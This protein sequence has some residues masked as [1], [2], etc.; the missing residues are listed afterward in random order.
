MKKIWVLTIFPELFSNFLKVG[1]LGQS[2]KSSNP[3]F[4]IEII[5]IRDYSLDKHNKVDDMPFGGG[6]GMVMRADV[7]ENAFLKGVVFKEGYVDEYKKNLH[8]VLAGPRG[9]VLTSDFAKSF[10]KKYFDNNIFSTP[11]ESLKNLV[12]IC[13]RY[14]GIDQRFI[15]LYVDQ[16]ISVGD[17]I[18][19]GGE[20]PVMIM[21]DVFSRFLKGVLGNGESLVD[22]SFEENLLDHNHYTRPQNF[23]GREVPS[24]LLSGHHA[25]IK[26][27]R[28]KERIE[29]TKSKRPDLY[30]NFID[31][32]NR[33]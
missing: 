22:E 18:L 30:S 24:V 25:K 11:T 4:S 6:P 27:E 7:L 26:E 20:L 16:E 14:E 10:C 19:S 31:K 32:K 12:F 15:D 9:D 8:V 28:L 33:G 3:A 21:I 5:D 13:G 1:V 17:Y 23:K 29:I 2:L